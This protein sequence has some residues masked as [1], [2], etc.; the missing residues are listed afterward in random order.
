M[1]HQQTALPADPWTDLSIPAS[2]PTCAY[3]PSASLKSK[4]ASARSDNR[5]PIIVA[6]TLVGIAVF[7]GVLVFAWQLFNAVPGTETWTPDPGLAAQLADEE[8]LGGYAMRPHP[9]INRNNS[10]TNDAFPEFVAHDWFNQDITVTVG[11]KTGAS[12]KPITRTELSDAA[13]SFVDDT[14]KFNETPLVGEPQLKHG[15]VGDWECVSASYSLETRNLGKDFMLAAGRNNRIWVL[16]DGTTLVYLQLATMHAFDSPEFALAEASIL[17]FRKLDASHSNELVASSGSWQPNAFVSPVPIRRARDSFPRLRVPYGP[18]NAE[19][20][21]PSLRVPLERFNT[22]FFISRYPSIY[23]TIENN[24]ISLADGQRIAQLAEPVSHARPLAVSVD[25]TLLV[26]HSSGSLELHVYDVRTAKPLGSLSKSF[27]STIEFLDENRVIAVNDDGTTVWDFRTGDV[28]QIPSPPHTRK[29]A[30]SLDRRQ[31]AVC[32]AQDMLVFDIDA[33]RQIAKMQRPN[34]GNSSAFADCIDVAFSDDGR[35]L[36]ASLENRI[37]CWSFRG[38]IVFDET[39]KSGLGV[40]VDRVTLEWIPDGSGWLLGKEYVVD[41]ESKRP[42]IIVTSPASTYR[43]SRFLDN[44]QLLIGRAK[45][46]IAI[47]IP[48]ERIKSAI[49][50]NG[51]GDGLLTRN[52]TT[53]LSVN[54][55]NVRFA[56]PDQVKRQLSDAFSARLSRDGIRTVPNAP[57]EFRLTYREVKGADIQY[58]QSKTFVPTL[59]PKGPTTNSSETKAALQVDLFSDNKIIWQTLI[60]QGAS[61]V[62]RGGVTPQSVRDAAFHDLL[63]SIE[64]AQLPYYVPRDSRSLP[65]PLVINP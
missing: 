1:P 10:F 5:L 48:W 33:D 4:P 65:L 18:V 11:I 49:A 47:T 17:T 59:R 54:I 12:H 30:V 40:P 31:L 9:E 39:I 45:E 13:I 64:T 63:K 26:A 23:S 50:A 16:S 58:V 7:M 20:I 14:A 28:R 22:G 15:R 41:R 25:G 43:R 2:D 21:S 51:R 37:I 46:L 29:T 19:M 36:A 44:N 27:V 6:A 35:E 62:V 38:A 60:T 32:T 55:E 34:S 3:A 61:Y 42:T 52:G 53:G 56:D 8:T 57:V 24:A